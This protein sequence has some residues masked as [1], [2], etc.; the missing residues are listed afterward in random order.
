MPPLDDKDFW[1]VQ[2]RAIRNLE[3][4]LADARPRAV[5]QMATGSG[6]TRCSIYHLILI[7]FDGV[8]RVLFLVDRSNLERQALKEFQPY[9]TPDD[10]RKFTEPYNVQRLTT[11]QIDPVARVVITTI[12]RLYSM[13][14]GEEQ[15][16][17]EL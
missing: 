5:I 11:N 13:L 1:P 4:P 17:T 7:K 6:K 2:E 14:K 15:L 10:H 9:V 8:Q 12:R 16:D 3:Q